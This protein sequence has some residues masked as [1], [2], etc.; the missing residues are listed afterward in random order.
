MQR[1]LNNGK[2]F[3]CT[4]KTENEE[5]PTEKD[6]VR[7]QT[8]SLFFYFSCYSLYNKIKLILYRPKG[9]STPIFSINP[10]THSRCWCPRFSTLYRIICSSSLCPLS[11]RQPIKSPTKSKSSPPPCSVWPCWASLWTRSSGCLWWFWWLCAH[12]HTHISFD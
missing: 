3:S 8:N 1:L 7:R 5:F 6:W 12:Y 11:T 4:I 9:D 10:P 2:C